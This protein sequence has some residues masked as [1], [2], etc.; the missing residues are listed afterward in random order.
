MR[1]REG[2]S[3]LLALSAPR[4][5]PALR[6]RSTRTPARSG[7]RRKKPKRCAK[8]RGRPRLRRFTEPA[9]PVSSLAHPPSS[10]PPGR[11]PSS[12]EPFA[13]RCRA[14]AVGWADPT[15]AGTDGSADH[16]G[17]DLPSRLFIL[18]LPCWLS[19]SWVRRSLC[20]ISR[21]LTRRTQLAFAAV[22]STPRPPPCLPARHQTGKDQVAIRSQLQRRPHTT[23]A[24]DRAGSTGAPNHP[25]PGAQRGTQIEVNSPATTTL[26]SA[27]HLNSPHPR[28]FDSPQNR[29]VPAANPRSSSI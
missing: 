27:R 22:T 18:C 3:P 8:S 21:T 15:H 13:R 16:V 17:N 23:S 11:S 5:A 2:V 7:T 26:P 14:A 20:S 9:R 28:P 12:V 29:L 1:S 25:N 19:L 4:L 6:N 10:P 24:P